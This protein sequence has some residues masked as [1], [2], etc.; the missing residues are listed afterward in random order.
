[1]HWGL[2]LIK[3]NGFQMDGRI[4][5]RAPEPIQHTIRTVN[6]DEIFVRSIDVGRT[7][8]SSLCN[9][10]GLYQPDASDVWNPDV[11]WQPIPVQRKCEEALAINKRR[12]ECDNEIG[13]DDELNNL[14]GV[15]EMR[16]NQIADLQQKVCVNDIDAIIRSLSDAAHSLLEA[17]AVI[18]HVLKVIMEMRRENIQTREGLLNA[19]EKCME[20]TK[21]THAL[22][23]EYEEAI[24]EYEE[25]ISVALT[26]EQEQRL[27]LQ[28]KQER[29][30]ETLLMEIENYKKI[31][32]G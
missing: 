17:R 4:P 23:L 6:E 18:K 20:A 11:N 21:S 26:P 24:A 13:I 29:K 2:R 3:S 15:Q 10:A 30:I 25:K 32:S 7:L 1:M 16:D 31:L 14:R 22:K 19:E 28:E 9:L 12:L 27:K 5:T 8:M